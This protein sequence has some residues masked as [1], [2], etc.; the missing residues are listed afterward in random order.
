MICVPF[1]AIERAC[2]HEQTTA[3]LQNNI[4]NAR[5]LK[6][7]NMAELLSQ[8]RANATAHQGGGGER[9]TL[10]LTQG[11]KG[12]LNVGTCFGSILV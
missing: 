5:N 10:G 4:N 8:T 11:R 6:T 9:C 3:D 1:G 7:P 12:G 2:A